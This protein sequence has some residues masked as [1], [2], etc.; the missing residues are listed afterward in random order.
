[1]GEFDPVQRPEHYNRHPSGVQ[2]IDLAEHLTYN[3]GSALKY[4]WRRDLKGA[5]R[6]DLEKALWFL[7]RQ[8]RLLCLLPAYPTRQMVL[9]GSEA[10]V[11]VLAKR[12]Q[13]QTSADDLLHRVMQ[14]L[15]EAV[16][17]SLPAS[18]SVR[19]WSSHVQ[20]ALAAESE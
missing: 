2:P 12:V 17:R 9:P 15:I 5:T 4:C 1:M 7:Q 19:K 13:D 16:A 8:D 10:V 18:D 3:F 14:V 11:G 6:Q 20:T